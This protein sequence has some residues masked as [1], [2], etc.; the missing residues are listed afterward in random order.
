MGAIYLYKYIYR[1]GG[2]S[3]GSDVVSHLIIKS[4]GTQTFMIKPCGGWK[5][6]CMQFV[7]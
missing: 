2:T 4:L 6:G 7:E 3:Y 5:L 1:F